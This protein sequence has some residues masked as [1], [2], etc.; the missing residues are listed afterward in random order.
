[1]DSSRLL[2]VAVRENV[3]FVPGD[4]F[5]ATASATGRQYF[6]LNFSNA[7]PDMI[8]EGI[9]RLALAIQQQMTGLCMEEKPIE[10]FSVSL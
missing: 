7:S 6:R 10:E 8:R 4:G 9:R 3:A 2:E 1:M 5:F